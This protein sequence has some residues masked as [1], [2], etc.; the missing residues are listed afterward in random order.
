MRTICIVF[1]ESEAC[2]LES[3]AEDCRTEQVRITVDATTEVNVSQLELTGGS[4]REIG[5][6][7]D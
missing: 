6:V 5:A 4:W 2:V 3:A 1:D 7:L